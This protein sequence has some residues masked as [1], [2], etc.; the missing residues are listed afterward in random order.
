MDAQ[1]FSLGATNGL[2]SVQ[3][4]LRVTANIF[5]GPILLL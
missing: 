5:D 2:E 1:T 3:C 4:M